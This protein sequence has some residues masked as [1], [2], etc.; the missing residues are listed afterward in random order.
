MDEKKSAAATPLKANLVAQ[1]FCRQWQV[2][3][4]AHWK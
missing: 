2:K 4:R 3:I 1:L